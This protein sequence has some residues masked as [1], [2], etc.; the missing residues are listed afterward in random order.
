MDKFQRVADLD[1]VN[2]GL[3]VVLPLSMA[4]VQFA[5]G[6]RVD[7]VYVTL[8]KNADATEVQQRLKTTLGPT[9]SVQ[10]AVNRRAATT[11]TTCCCPCW[12][13]SR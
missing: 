10:P 3:V 5:R 11:S 8:A 1:N 6:D 4:K 9:Y 7:M 12:A 2:N 13:S